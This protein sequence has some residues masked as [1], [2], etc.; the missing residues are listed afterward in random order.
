M[1]PFGE[2]THPLHHPREIGQIEAAPELSGQ[3]F[4]PRGNNLLAVPGTLVLPGGLAG[5]GHQPFQ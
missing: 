2:G 3:F 5:S 4:Q 1:A